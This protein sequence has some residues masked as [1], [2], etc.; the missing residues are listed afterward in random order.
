MSVQYVAEASQK[1]TA[2][3]VTGEPPAVTVAVNATALPEATVVT[4]LPAD[5]A[6]RAVT[7]GT[8]CAIPLIEPPQAAIK[9]AARIP[10]T[11]R[12]LT[13]RLTLDILKDRA[14][15]SNLLIPYAM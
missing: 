8:A 7:V 3:D 10:G 6:A 14:H 11:Q 13:C 2:P 9:R 5:V 1:F 12:V 15:E 4:A